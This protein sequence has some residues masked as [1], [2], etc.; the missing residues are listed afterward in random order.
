MNV[1]V[2]GIYR[3][4]KGDYYLVIDI[5]YNAEDMT[6]WAVYRS[7]YGDGKLFIRSLDEFLMKV[8]KEK[9][10]NCDQDNRFELQK[11]KSVRGE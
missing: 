2:N 1:K 10:P 3:R 9:Y 7:L 11:I 4:F 8:D 5:A 6:K